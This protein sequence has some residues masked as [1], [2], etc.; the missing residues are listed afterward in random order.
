MSMLSNILWDITSLF[1]PHTCPVCHGRILRD[2]LAVCT[3]C[4]ITAPLTNLWEE[5]DNVMTQRFWG[6]IP[7]Q[8]AAALFWFVDGSPW[9]SAIHHFK[10]GGAWLTA[11]NMGRWL[12][13][14]LRQSGNFDDIDLVVPI[15][16]H[17]RRRLL[18]GYNQS[19]YIA[20]GIAVELG[21]KVDFRTLYR[22]RYN[23]S[24]TSKHIS[25]RWG[26]VEGIFRVRNAERFNGKHILLV[27]DVLTT[28][29]TIIS[30]A[31]TILNVTSECKI[32]V[33][34]LATTRRSVGLE[35]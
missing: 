4:E 9:R 19:E 16:L 31:E 24:Q 1:A 2:N 15:P 3:M 27:D 13:R 32:S 21:V 29:A 6:I 7:I 17:W 8:R 26:N 35:P 20:R 11:Y 28:G 5:A 22:H 18:R 14:L 23:H 10:Y 33:A 25:E 30:A 12:G 34:T